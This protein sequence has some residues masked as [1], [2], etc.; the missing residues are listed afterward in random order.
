[1]RTLVND[2]PEEQEQPE[3]NIDRVVV[4]KTETFWSFL[5]AFFASI[6]HF[7][8]RVHGSKA[9][10]KAGSNVWYGEKKRKR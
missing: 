6:A 4:E 8:Q 9:L 5:K 1:M 2:D 10:R 7:F 3:E